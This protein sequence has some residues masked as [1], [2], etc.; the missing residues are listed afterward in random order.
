MERTWT[1][2][3]LWEEAKRSQGEVSHLRWEGIKA[4][5]HH[6]AER[7]EQEHAEAVARG[8]RLLKVVLEH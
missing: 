3:E 8:Q 2:A 4:F 1:V 7:E 6:L 5:L